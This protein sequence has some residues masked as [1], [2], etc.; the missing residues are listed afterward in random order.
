MKHLA[1]SR[2]SHTPPG[3]GGCRWIIGIWETKKSRL[4]VSERAKISI[5]SGRRPD[6]F[7]VFELKSLKKHCFYKAKHVFGR[8]NYK[9]ISPAALQFVEKTPNVFCL[10]QNL[11]LTNGFFYNGGGLHEY[12]LILPKAGILFVWF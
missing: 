11:L 9:K 10:S 5:W 7:D 6:I 8:Q 12:G 2:I 1:L 3:V 4:L